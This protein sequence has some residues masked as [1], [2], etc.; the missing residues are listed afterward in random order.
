MK[1]NGKPN[2]GLWKG[3]QQ[4]YLVFFFCLYTILTAEWGSETWLFLSIIAK[5]LKL[6]N[7]LILADEFSYGNLSEEYRMEVPACPSPVGW[8]RAAYPICM[9]PRYSETKILWLLKQ[10]WSLHLTKQSKQN[11]KVTKSFCSFTGIFSK[12]KYL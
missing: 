7:E 12:K 2:Y 9:R 10:N 8:M 5:D 1:S 3:F 4:D 6:W 11:W